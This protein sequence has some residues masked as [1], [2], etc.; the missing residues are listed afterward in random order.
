MNMKLDLEVLDYRIRREG[1]LTF[2]YKPDMAHLWGMACK[3]EPLGKISLLNGRSPLRFIEPDMVVRTLMHGG[4]FRHITGK[5]FLTPNRTMRELKASAHLISRGILTPEIIAV[6]LIK[7]G[8]FYAIDVISRLIPGAVDL[9]MYLETVH[10]DSAE[11][12]KKSGMLIRKI[13]DSG[14]YHADLHIKN[15]LLDDTK[16]LW[17]LDLDKA[18]QF[19]RLPG[20]M[21]QLNLKRFMRSVKKWQAKGRIHL[22]HEWTSIFLNGY[23]RPS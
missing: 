10:E 22:P 2:I 17:V 11:L 13:H 4:L 1:R 9:L 20:I 21:K 19:D 14:V 15:I 16:N 5:R 12:L 23:Y 8:P 18:H 6:R 7:E 3:K